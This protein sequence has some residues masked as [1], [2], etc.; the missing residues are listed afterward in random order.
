MT[1]PALVAKRLAAIETYVRE[2][3][4]LADPPAITPA[5]CGAT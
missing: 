2:L 5:P 3:R 4:E 1:D